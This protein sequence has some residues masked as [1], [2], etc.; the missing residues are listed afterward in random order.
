MRHERQRGRTS[1]DFHRSRPRLLRRVR[2]SDE[3]AADLRGQRVAGLE[4]PVVVPRGKAMTSFGRAAST[5]ARALVLTRVRRANVPSISGSSGAN[6]SYGPSIVI[7][8]SPASAR[9]PS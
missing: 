6:E 3:R 8:V 4:Q 5:N 7:T 2:R 1:D 9:S